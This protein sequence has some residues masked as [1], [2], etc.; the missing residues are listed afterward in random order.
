MTPRAPPT[1][2]PAREQLEKALAKRPWLTP[3][4]AQMFVGAYDPARL[5]LADRLLTMLPA[6]PLHGLG[7]HDDRDWTAID[8]WSETVARA[9]L[10]PAE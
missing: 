3:V 10:R 9:L 5:R 8:E 4:S 7:A 6:S 2:S 1:I